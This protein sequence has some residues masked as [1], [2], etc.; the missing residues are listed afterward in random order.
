[1]EVRAY[2]YALVLNRP[3]WVVT[4]GTVMT[5]EGTGYTKY[6]SPDRCTNI[7]TTAL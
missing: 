6:N 1:M 5:D 7:I 4:L 2:A 3:T